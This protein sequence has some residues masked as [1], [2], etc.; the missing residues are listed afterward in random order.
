MSFLPYSKV[1]A[2]VN[3]VTLAKDGYVLL[4]VA[5]Q[6][7]HIYNPKPLLSNCR[8]QVPLNDITCLPNF[9]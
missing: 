2:L 5:T 4:P 6:Q 7:C 8:I 3:I 9:I 1:H